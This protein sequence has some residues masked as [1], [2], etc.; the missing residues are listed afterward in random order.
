MNL[1]HLRSFYITVKCNSISKA[2]KS[3]HLT[4]PGLSMQLQSLENEI[5][6]SLLKRSPRGVELTNEG[7]MVFEYASTMLSLEDNIQR[8]LKRFQERKPS[9]LVGSCKSIGEYALPCSIYTFKQ[10]HEN[11]DISLNL[12]NSA[13]IIKKLLDHDINIG[14]IQECS[15]PDNIVMKP[16]LSDNLILV[17]GYNEPINSINIDGLYNLPIILREEGSST[18]GILESSLKKLNIDI[19]DL[20]IRYSLNSQ[21][22]IK[23]SIISGRGFSFLPEISVRREIRDFSIKKI[24]IPELTVDFNYYVAFRKDYTLSAHEQLFVDFLCSKKRCFCY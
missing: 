20:N 4:Q 10:I 23:S 17:G 24:N 12:D 3:L 6:V 11:I 7:K 9:L 2:A 8:D 19:N 15:A 18:R 13:T 21:E 1:G 16:I 22:A 14:I 5:G